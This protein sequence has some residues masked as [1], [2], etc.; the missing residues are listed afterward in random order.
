MTTD[1]TGQ[2]CA[3]LSDGDEYGLTCG[4]WTNSADAVDAHVLARHSRDKDVYDV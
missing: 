1:E 2:E 4:F 3:K